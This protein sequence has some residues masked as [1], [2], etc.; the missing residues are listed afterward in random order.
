MTLHAKILTGVVGGLAAFAAGK[1]VSVLWKAATKSDIDPEDPTSK[2]AAAVCFASTSA[3]V[4]AAARVL[5]V[6]FVNKNSAQICSGQQQD[7]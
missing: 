1:L 6:R 2:L 3:A 7:L 4:A 5:A